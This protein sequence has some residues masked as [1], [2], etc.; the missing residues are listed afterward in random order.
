[1]V[2][3]ILYALLFGVL[4]LFLVVL[5]AAISIMGCISVGVGD[6]SVACEVVAATTAANTVGVVTM[7][8]SVGVPN[9]IY[10]R[11][12]GGAIKG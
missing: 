2:G 7:D 6:G 8:C 12:C 10:E 9:D 11:S 5:A 4:L 3:E 1:M